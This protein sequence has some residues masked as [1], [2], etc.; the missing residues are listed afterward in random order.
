MILD[1]IDDLARSETAV[2]QR[3]FLAP[4]V[5]GVRLRVSVEGLVH[6]FVPNPRGYAGWGVFQPSMTSAVN[7]AG[8]IF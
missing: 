7:M 4:C 5:P 2:M 8:G 1:L 6:E 3:R